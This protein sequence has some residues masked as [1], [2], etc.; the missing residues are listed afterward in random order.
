MLSNS[1]LLRRTF[2]PMLLLA[3]GACS[4]A[5]TLGNVLGSV[6]GGGGTSNQV[7]GTIQGVDT[8]NR[9]IGIRQSNGQTVAVSYDQNTKVIYQNP[10]YAITNLETGD[11]VTVTVQDN[12]NGGYYTSTVQVTQSVSS[13]STSNGQTGNATSYQGAVRQ[14]DRANGLFTID[15]QNAG[16]IT[17]Y[18]PNNLGRADTDRYN[19]LRSGDNV[20][21]YAYRTN[22]SSQ[23]QLQQFY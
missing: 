19:N 13:G 7:A 11:A 4:S 12:G 10:Q 5:G 2:A 6:L 22:N 9:Q 21:F 23:V 8:R 18:L 20:R 16:R 3:L 15:D 14:V 1:S 17:V